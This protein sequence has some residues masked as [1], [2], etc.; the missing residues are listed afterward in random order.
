MTIVVSFLCTDGV[1][2]SADSM[3]TSRMGNVDV[4]HHTGKKLSI[5][6]GQQLFA[7]AGDHGQGDRFRIR[8]DR[9]HAEM[10][11]AQHAIDYALFISREMFAEFTS[12][13]INNNVDVATVLAYPYGD[14]HVCCVYEGL[15]Q[16]RLLDNNH[17]YSAFGIGKLS[18]DPF[19]RFLVDV[20]CQNGMPT[21]REGVFLATWAIEHVIQTTPGGVAGPIRVGV[22][23]RSHENR[24][25]ARELPDEEIDEH[26]QAKES[27]IDALRDWQEN[28]QGGAND[29][30]HD[31]FPE[32]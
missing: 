13:G 5:L 15:V 7:F 8:A 22:L 14:G 1:V 19:L 20:F 18:A 26:R 31:L 24:L 10:T 16:P 6:N 9:C 17:F 21:V 30:G 12:T 29:A 25:V 11:N 2:V 27:A 32:F 23:E 4:A 3:L 28:I